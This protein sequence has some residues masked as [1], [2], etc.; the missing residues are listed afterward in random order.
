MSGSDSLKD[1]LVAIGFL[2]DDARIAAALAFLSSEEVFKLDDLV[3]TMSCVDI[4]LCS[5]CD[6]FVTLRR[7]I[8]GPVGG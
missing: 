8:R 4:C 2:L 3:G 5:V 1:E 7:H 6:L